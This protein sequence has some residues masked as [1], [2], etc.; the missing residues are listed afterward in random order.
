MTLKAAFSLLAKYF[1]RIFCA[2]STLLMPSSS[3]S[4]ASRVGR[5]PVSVPQGSDCPVYACRIRYKSLFI[6]SFVS[7]RFP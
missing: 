6:R 3:I 7:F 4:M 5:I 1:S 2:A